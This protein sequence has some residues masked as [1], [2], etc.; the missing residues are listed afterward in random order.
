MTKKYRLVYLNGK[1]TQ[2][3]SWDNMTETEMKEFQEFA[4]KCF[5]GTVEFKEEPMI[6]SVKYFDTRKNA[7]SK[8][9]IRVKA[10]TREEAYTKVTDILHSKG[11]TD[12]TFVMNCSLVG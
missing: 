1:K 5:Y 6:Y 9:G 3:R 10:E 7:W 12:N 8:K 11:Y 4:T 2:W